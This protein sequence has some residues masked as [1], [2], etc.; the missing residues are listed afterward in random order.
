VLQ[1]EEY[2]D[3]TQCAVDIGEEASV[4]DILLASDDSSSW[5]ILPASLVFNVVLAL[6]WIL[7]RK[8]SRKVKTN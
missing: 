4:A 1:T 5:W 8:R 6:L 7:L 2:L 3:V